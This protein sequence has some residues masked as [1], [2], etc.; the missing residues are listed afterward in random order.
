MAIEIVVP[1][2]G[3]TMEEGTFAEWLKKDGDH[4]QEGEALFVL[5]GDKAAQEIESFDSGILRIPPNAPTPGTVV[6]VGA[7][8]GYL[9]Q[10]GEFAPF[11]LESSSAAVA[12]PP[13]SI[14]E[15][16]KP[17]QYPARAPE[18]V[19][20]NEE[21]TPKAEVKISPRARRA[22]RELGVD[23][24]TIEGS[25][26]TGR[27]VERDVRAAAARGESKSISSSRKPIDR[28]VVPQAF[29]VTK[30]R[31]II[32]ERMLA[33]AQSTAPVTLTTKADA[34]H[35]VTLRDQLKS[36]SLARGAVVPAYTDLL[37]KLVG[38]AL[39]QHPALNSVWQ[40]DEILL[41]DEI[42]IGVAVDTDAGLM[43]PVIRDVPTKSIRQIAEESHALVER[44][45]SGRLPGDALQG[46]TFSIS[47]LGMHGI[48]AFTPIINLPQCA[49]LG[50][51]R[52]VTEPAVDN[53]QIVPRAM[54]ALSLTFDHRLVDGAP[55]AR[56]LDTVRRFVEQPFPP[57]LDEP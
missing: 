31:R 16:P 9:V 29:P 12:A 54:L 52:I 11:E 44:A 3:W 45:R 42:H 28:A 17:P 56:F 55:A 36:A 23:W 34:T 22:A 35:L 1:R 30:V 43:V 37:V 32:A 10:P 50:M 51:G 25:G 48:D 39:Q 15:Q 24:E 26:R 13:P 38:L 40:R 2:L 6:A 18:P 7:V 8:L 46:G 27:I 4:V 20:E 33:G 5:D 14:I 57:L 21:N 19:Q 49:I 47:N 53:G 41:L